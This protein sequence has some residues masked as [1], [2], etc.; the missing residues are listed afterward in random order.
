MGELLLL[1]IRDRCE[2][3]VFLG[4]CSSFMLECRH[5]VQSYS[6]HP[7]TMW[8][9]VNTEDGGQR[10]GKNL[11]GLTTLLCPGSLF[12]KQ[13]QYLW[14][15]WILIRVAKHIRKAVRWDLLRVGACRALST[16]AIITISC[17]NVCACG[18][19]TCSCLHTWA[20]VAGYARYM[21]M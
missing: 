1:H 11:G 18:A 5:D 20:C 14:L 15:S 7:V 4:H 17:A 3:R 2:R 6:S 8:H 13:L 12:N 21:Y 16:V 10:D 19:H 9:Q